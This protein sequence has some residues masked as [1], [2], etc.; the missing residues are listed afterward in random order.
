[1]FVS[2]QRNIFISASLSQNILSNT[3]TLTC[4]FLLLI[5]QDP[6]QTWSVSWDSLTHITEPHSCWSL[7]FRPYFGH[8]MQRTDAF[9]KTLMLGK[10]EDWRRKGQQRMRWLDGITDSMDMSLSKLQEVLMDREAWRTAV[11]GVA[12]SQTWLSN[13]TERNHVIRWFTCLCIFFTILQRHR[14]SFSCP[15]T[16]STRHI[17]GLNSLCFFV[18]WVYFCLCRHHEMLI[19]ITVIVNIYQMLLILGV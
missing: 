12:K 19:I 10:I 11:H 16:L 15:Y 3:T 2:C 17:A 6:S 13:W 7:V 5:F 9:E 8:L 1:M 4:K 18:K 14:S